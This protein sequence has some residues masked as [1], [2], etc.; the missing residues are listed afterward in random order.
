MMNKLLDL[1]MQDNDAN[2]LTVRDYL[3]ALLTQLITD[4][5]GFSSKRPFGNSDWANDLYEPLFRAKL[6]EWDD[7]QSAE[8]MI[9]EVVKE[10]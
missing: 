4:K 5:D 1:P 8:K 9:L 3:K 7:D 6:V 10:M 2:A